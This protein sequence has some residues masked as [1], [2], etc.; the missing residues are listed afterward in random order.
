MKDNYVDINFSGKMK[1]KFVIDDL[2]T[3]IESYLKKNKIDNL[4]NCEKHR[5]VIT[6]NFNDG[7]SGIFTLDI[8]TSI[9]YRNPY[10]F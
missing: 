1:S 2:F 8:I 4:W 10:T 7:I 6:I 9:L 5:N 3:K